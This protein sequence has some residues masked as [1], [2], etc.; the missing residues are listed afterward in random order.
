MRI[1]IKI[2]VKTIGVFL[3]ILVSKVMCA[4]VDIPNNIISVNFIAIFGPIHPNLELAFEH[5]LNDRFSLEAGISPI[6]FGGKKDTQWP[7]VSA[8]KGWILRIE[9]KYVIKNKIDQDILTQNFIS[10][11]VYHAWSLHTGHRYKKDA[12]GDELHSYNIKSKT[13]GVVPHLGYRRFSD[14]FMLEFSGGYGRRFI[15]IEN[16]YPNDFSTLSN[17]HRTSYTPEQDGKH[18]WYLLSANAKVGATF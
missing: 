10:F 9:P 1:G 17:Y 4:Q 5:R 2:R 15:Q 18:N 11:E 14:H 13:L 6:L 7:H 3:T 16:D 8:K 12:I